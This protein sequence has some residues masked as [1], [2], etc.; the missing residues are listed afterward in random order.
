MITD[1]P[2]KSSTIPDSEEGVPVPGST[3]V[4]TPSS[5]TPRCSHADISPDKEKGHSLSA[6]E[7]NEQYTVLE[8]SLRGG[9]QLRGTI[10]HR[11]QRDVGV[12]ERVEMIDMNDGDGMKEVIIIDWTPDD[13]GV[14]FL[15]PPHDYS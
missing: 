1:P 10:S 15:R 2:R 4:N 9:V 12:L 13:P 11:S 8:S 14:S 7:Q 6:K 5:L 3:A